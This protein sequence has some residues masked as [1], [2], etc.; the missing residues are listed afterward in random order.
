ML[1]QTV[2][3][4]TPLCPCVNDL[5]N[6]TS[7]RPFL[8]NPAVRLLL[9]PTADG[10]NLLFYFVILCEEVLH[11]PGLKV[12]PGLMQKKRFLTVALSVQ[13]FEMLRV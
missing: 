2:F 3:E 12:N 4:V 11:N 6:H 10:G 9:F 1:S 7:L 13:A 8:Q 5:A